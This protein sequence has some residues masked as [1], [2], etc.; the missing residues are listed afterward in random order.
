M[1]VLISV[2]NKSNLEKIAKFLDN[3]NCNIISTGGTYNHLKNIKV[4]NLSK[5]SEITNSPEILDGRVKTLHPVIHGGILAKRNNKKHLDEIN[6]ISGL[7]IDMVIVN[8]YPF[9]ET[10]LNSENT[11]EQ[12]I[13]MID[14]G[15]P[16]LIRAA[17]KNYESVA[18]LVNPNKYELIT[19]IT[20][21]TKKTNISIQDLCSIEERKIL[22]AEAFEHVS[23]YDS[24]I[25]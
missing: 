23:N 16:T 4:K 22:A 11:H 8:L 13:E 2:S 25:H 6:N 18:V 20:A 21:S 24:I 3:L 15:G 9:E 5:V 7:F 19:K 12:I 14:I 1:N 10:L 17:A